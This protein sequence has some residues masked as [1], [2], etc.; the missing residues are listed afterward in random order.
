VRQYY[1]AIGSRYSLTGKTMETEVTNVS[2]DHDILSQNVSNRYD[3]EGYV[4]VSNVINADLISEARQDVSWLQKRYGDKSEL[5]QIANNNDDPFWIRLVSD[6]NLLDLA[7]LFIGPDIGLFA[8]GYFCKAPFCFE[9]LILA[10]INIINIQLISK[11]GICHSPAA[12][13]GV[14]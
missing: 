4:I 6:E 14:E 11:D 13:D 3:R 9:A 2:T 8:S 10:S 5:M 12:S 7:Q 1:F